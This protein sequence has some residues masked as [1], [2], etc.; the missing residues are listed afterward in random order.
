MGNFESFLI[1]SK[2]KIE[3]LDVYTDTDNIDDYSILTIKLDG[4]VYQISK[5]LIKNLD[6]YYSKYNKDE[7]T[8]VRVNP[9]QKLGSIKEIKI[10]NSNLLDSEEKVSEVIEKI[11]DR[12]YEKYNFLVLPP[13]DDDIEEI[14]VSKY[15]SKNVNYKESAISQKD[16]GKQRLYS[17]GF[18][19]KADD[20]SESEYFPFRLFFRFGNNENG[21][22]VVD[23]A[24]EINE[25]STKQISNYLINSSYKKEN[26]EKLKLM[27][28][29]GEFEED[30][31]LVNSNIEDVINQ[32]MIIINDYCSDYKKAPNWFKKSKL[33]KYL[34]TQELTGDEKNIN[35]TAS[36]RYITQTPLPYSYKTIK[37][38]NLFDMPENY[39]IKVSKIG[40]KLDYELNKCPICGEVIN[41]NNKLVVSDQY[42]KGF[43]G[44]ESCM[45][46]KC[47]TCGA[48]WSNKKPTELIGKEINGK[49]Y[50]KA[51]E[52]TNVFCN[53]YLSYGKKY[54]ALHARKCDSPECSD[55]I[56]G[57][58]FVEACSNPSCGK[59]YC[60][61]HAKENFLFCESSLCASNPNKYCKECAKDN[62]HKCSYCGKNICDSCKREVL[63]FERNHYIL[64]KKEFICVDCLNEM[65]DVNNLEV[66]KN[67]EAL[68]NYNGKYYPISNNLVYKYKGIEGQYIIKDLN[69]AR[70]A[71]EN[72]SLDPELYYRKD[73]VNKCNQCG[74]YFFHLN[75]ETDGNPEEAFCGDCLSTCQ[76]C[77][78]KAAKINAYSPDSKENWYCKYC[79]ED[80]WY[81]SD[82]GKDTR[83][84]N[85]K[86][87]IIKNAFI[88]QRAGEDAQ[89][90]PV[91]KEDLF[92]C[93]STRFSVDK[94]I[95]T[96]ECKNCKKRY[97]VAAFE[98]NSG[99]CKYCNKI[100]KQ[101]DKDI[102]ESVNNFYTSKYGDKSRFHVVIDENMLIIN[103]DNDKF[104]HYIYD[105]KT[106]K[107]KAYKG[108]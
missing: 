71:R 27:I 57:D 26:K 58:D 59:T 19:I 15:I 14:D 68:Q 1:Q 87:N 50:Y 17:I 103:Y 3:G 20:G 96:K 84:I 106:G 65:T 54:C 51:G 61:V 94:N 23:V 6:N 81:F 40:G 55:E 43:I 5:D 7:I 56:Y 108:R 39:D 24:H 30:K 74:N 91:K 92:I 97:A 29:N 79:Y 28:D 62:L 75:G 78:R 66:N 41:E 42:T 12:V 9:Y 93:P 101:T 107:Y 16:T 85:D 35:A 49:K 104:E 22:V 98:G 37:V 64:S 31:R 4:S 72:S 33:G 83:V 10:S 86:D 32:I 8:S 48:V 82:L 45:T 80:K 89:L 102:L 36:F 52:V 67:N 21:E 2:N 69:M 95:Q 100:D 60:K 25:L 47:D 105:K 76:L 46:A 44:C 90:L 63:E 77:G 18:K 38:K 70:K 34:E 53:D 11:V 13:T 99:F 73:E 88:D